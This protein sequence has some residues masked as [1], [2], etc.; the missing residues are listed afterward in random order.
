MDGA[1]GATRDGSSASD[2]TH[3]HLRRVRSSFPPTPTRSSVPPTP[4]PTGCCNGRADPVKLPNDTQSTFGRNHGSVGSQSVGKRRRHVSPVDVG[5]SDA[6]ARGGE[7][8]L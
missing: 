8:I 5:R 4:T 1:R 7:E 6:A 3:T 2:A